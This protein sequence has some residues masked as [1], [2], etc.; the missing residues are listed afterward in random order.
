MIRCKKCRD[1][2]KDGSG[3]WGVCRNELTAQ[4]VEHWKR[5]KTLTFE[6]FGC[7]YGHEVRKE[8]ADEK[9]RRSRRK[10]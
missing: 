2:E 3:G 7:V 8:K 6:T 4:N 9:E 1:W 10:A 5:H